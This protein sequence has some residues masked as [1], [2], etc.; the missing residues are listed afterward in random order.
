MKVLLCGLAAAAA[1]STTIPPCSAFM[2]GGASYGSRGAGTKL[3]FGFNGLGSPKEEEKPEDLG[4]KEDKKISLGGLAQLVTAGMGAPFLG[5][6]QGMDEETGKMMF[7]LEAN[8][9]V[10]EDGNSKQTQMPYFENGWV[11]E[12]DDKTSSTPSG[13]FKLPWQN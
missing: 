5:D 13:G 12:E 1:V 3:M 8:N 2:G 9:L 10:D 11:E 7:S 6:Y 4:K